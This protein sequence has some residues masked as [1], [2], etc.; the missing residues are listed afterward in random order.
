L[1]DGDG[2]LERDEGDGE[3]GHWHGTVSLIV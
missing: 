3:A 2:G 1:L